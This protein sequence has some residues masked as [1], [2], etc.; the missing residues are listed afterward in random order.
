M[1]VVAAMVEFMP[2]VCAHTVCH[3]PSLKDSYRYKERERERG[4]LGPD[5]STPLPHTGK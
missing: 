1:C 4:P 2:G 3:L 5:V